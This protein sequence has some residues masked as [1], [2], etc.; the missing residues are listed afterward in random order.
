MAKTR[1]Y[2]ITDVHG[3]NRC[4][5]KFLNAA[6]FYSA[7]CLILGGDITGKVMIPIVEDAN[8]T[9]TC[10][11][12]GT[13]QV[14][15]SKAELDELII[16]ASDSGSY[17]KLVSPKE[18][19]ELSAD[20]K[21]VKDLFNELMV[22]RVKAWMALAE[23]RLGKTSV[24]CWISPG[25]DDIFQI[26]PVLSSSGYVVNPEE[27]VVNLDK[28]HE[29]ITLGTT[30]RTPWNSEREVDE[31]DLAVKI[32]AMATKVQNMKTAIFN[33]HVPPINT[34]IDQAPKIDENLKVVVQAGQ[35]QMIS[36]GSTAC[37]AALEKYQPML[38]LHGHIHE[39]RGIV[40]IG[41]TMC[42]N[43]GSEYGEGILK[44]FLADIEGEKVKSHLLT[45]G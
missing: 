17:T 41:K 24:T 15:K 44:G 9:Y 45:S 42:V 4:F 11:Y 3:S 5:R 14:L 25:N 1:I 43:P 28:D 12:Q 10:S 38:G 8:G 40:N 16:K 20:P 23:E 26:D 27:R 22:E 29:M 39:S 6:K 34:P 31:P 36:A 19:E 18:F 7:D 30:N 32:D 37:R 21:K 2:F 35:V 13:Q 33:I